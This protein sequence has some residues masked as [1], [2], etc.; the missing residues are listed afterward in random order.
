[1]LLVLIQGYTT[2]Y[3]VNKH[4]KRGTKSNNFMKSIQLTKAYNPSNRPLA[5]NNHSSGGGYC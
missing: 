5:S 3:E 1:M 4:Q 2:E